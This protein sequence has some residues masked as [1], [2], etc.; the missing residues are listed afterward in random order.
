MLEPS[1]IYTGNED[2]FQSPLPLS[3]PSLC[4]RMLRFPSLIAIHFPFPIPLRITVL[5]PLVVLLVKLGGQG[6]VGNNDDVEGAGSV[7]GSLGS[8]TTGVV[9]V[10]AGA[11]AVPGVAGNVD[12]SLRGGTSGRS[13]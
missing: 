4:S 10:L 5:A 13:A 3:N 7:L 1:L 11:I 6:D 8:V 2:G 12:G 9:L